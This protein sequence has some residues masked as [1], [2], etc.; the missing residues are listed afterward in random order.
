MRILYFYPH[1]MKKEL[2]SVMAGTAPSDRMYGLIE[3]QR[4][5]HEV[6]LTDSRFQGVFAKLVTWLKKI[7]NVNL[8]DYGSLRMLRA[9]DV[10]VVKDDFST[11]LTIACRV[12]RKKI[13]YVDALFDIPK[14]VLLQKICKLNIKL[15]DGIVVYSKRQIEQ[16]SHLLNIPSTRFKALPYTIDVPFYRYSYHKEKITEPYILSVGRDLGRD[17]KTLVEAMEGLGLRLK[18]VTLPYLL[19]GVYLNQPWL[20]ILQNVTYERLFQLYAEALFVVIP[21]KKGV[22][23]PSGIRSL[24]EAMALGKSIISTYSPVLE[25]YAKNGEGVLYVEPENCIELRN[26]IEDLGKDPD[27]CVRVG[28]KGQER[29]QKYNMDVYTNAFEDYLTVLSEKI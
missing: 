8:I 17:F 16:W 11:L 12:F 23:Y 5:G 6:S 22:M 13:V 27:Y 14:K 4:R 28:K 9:Y 10:I 15:S 29:V 18:I 21:L 3:L 7:Y 2:Q 24:L 1:P 25:E 19:R 20:E 26:K